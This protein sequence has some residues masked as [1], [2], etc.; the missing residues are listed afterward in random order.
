MP[1]GLPVVVKDNLEKCRSAA[2][3]AVRTVR[4]HASNLFDKLGVRSR[5]QAIAFAHD[6]GIS[7]KDWRGCRK[8]VRD[9][10]K[11]PC[12]RTAQGGDSNPFTAYRC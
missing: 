5:A 12:A 4:N 8:G 9:V 6:H 11:P 1:K 10:E 7:R 2:I 3:A